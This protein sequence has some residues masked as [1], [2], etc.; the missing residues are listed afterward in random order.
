MKCN[1]TSVIQE[2]KIGSWL[3]KFRAL[4]YISNAEEQVKCPDAVTGTALP[5]QY[6]QKEI[7]RKYNTGSI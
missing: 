4:Y 7:S 1:I 2:K 6:Y 5:L 3:P